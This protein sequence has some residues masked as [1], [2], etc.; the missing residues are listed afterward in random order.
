MTG[1]I[2][3]VEAT[4]YGPVGVCRPARDREM[5]YRRLWTFMRDR[6]TCADCLA[7]LANRATRVR[8]QRTAAAA[9]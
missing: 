4:P 6:V 8:K 9:L 1:F 3:Y 7:V 2:H 5:T